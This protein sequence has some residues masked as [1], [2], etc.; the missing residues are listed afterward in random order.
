M[1]KSYT[2][3]N[4]PIIFPKIIRKYDY[5]K[6]LGCGSTCVVALV[7]DRKTK[8]RFAAKIIS[9]KDVTERK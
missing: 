1:I 9:K 8:E 3:D 6:M 7:E 4:Y 2:E 5:I